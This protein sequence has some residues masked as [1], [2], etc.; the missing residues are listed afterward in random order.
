M[1][2][3]DDQLK[4]LLP[5][6]ALGMATP[7]EL[8]AVTAALEVDAALRTE[9]GQVQQA[10]SGIPQSL[11]PPPELKV[12][13]LEAIRQPGAVQPEAVQPVLVRPEAVRLELH[14]APS[15][16]APRA[17]P[18][19]RGV[20]RRALWGGLAAAGLMVLAFS[21]LLPRAIS[22]GAVSVVAT[23]GDGGLIVGNS[24][25]SNAVLIRPNRSRVTVKLSANR[26]SHFTDATS[27]AGLSYL[28]DAANQR[29][30]IVDEQS[31]QLIDAWPVPAGAASVAVQGDIVVVKG[32]ISGTLALFTKTGKGEK[33]M[34]ETR[35]APRTD[36][37]MFSVMDQAV[38]A[39]ELIFTTHH[40]TGEVSVLDQNT[41]L[42]LR[43]FKNLG[44]PV[45]L[46]RAGTAL[47]VLDYSGRLLELNPQSGAVLRKVALSGNPDR[48]S[49]MDD[50]AF[51]SDRAGFV[52]AVRLDTLEVLGRVAVNGEPMDISLMPGLHLAVAISKGGVIVLDRD[53][54]TLET[55]N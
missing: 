18:R 55:I 50:L 4:E 25:A 51:L 41:G 29:L 33:T 5:L 9:Y 8:R 32:A 46:A 38:I 28:L 17:S 47:L 35:V 12:R 21:A 34:L 2:F 26:Q 36:M 13:L 37:A 40:V 14:N 27:S 10:L 54:K 39:R 19:P 48:L 11:T 23:T 52:T 49:V 15:H 20:P 1:N 3:T 30:F 31:G 43:R 6:I 24:S 7:E 45:A 44:K 22:L 16:S 53:L 42:E